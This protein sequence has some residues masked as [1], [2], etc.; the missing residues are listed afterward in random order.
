MRE[1]KDSYGS[2]EM[3]N[4]HNTDVNMGNRYGMPQQHQQQQHPQMM[5]MVSILHLLNLRLISMVTI[6]YN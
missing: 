6:K 1:D 2:H 5:N 4:K 3:L